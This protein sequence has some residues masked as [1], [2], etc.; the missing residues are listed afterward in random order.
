MF[1]SFQEMHAALRPWFKEVSGFVLHQHD[2]VTWEHGGSQSMIS[3]LGSLHFLLL[4]L[5]Q[6]CWASRNS[7]SDPCRSRRHHLWNA[8]MQAKTVTQGGVCRP[9][10]YQ[11]PF[12]TDLE[13]EAQR[14]LPACLWSPGNNQKSWD[15]DLGLSPVPYWA[16]GCQGHHLI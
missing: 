2:L 1:F 8:V 10:H 9:C 14:R 3:F 4:P 6:V 11:L 12:S 15:S 7:I 16:G 13:A 5:L